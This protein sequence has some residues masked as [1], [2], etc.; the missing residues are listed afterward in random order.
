MAIAEFG[1]FSLNRRELRETI[2][3]KDALGLQWDVKEARETKHGFDILYGKRH[4]ATE[5]DVGGPNRL[6]YTHELKA[7]WEKHAIDHDG[8]I[9]DLPAGRTTLKRARIALGFNWDKDS[10]K[11]WRKRKEDM[12]TLKPREFEEK[13]REH[14]VTG[15]RMSFWRKRMVGGRARPLDWWKETG[16]LNIL[17]SG[18]S[19][20][21]MRKVLPEKISTTQAGRLRRRARQCYRLVDGEIQCIGPDP[22]C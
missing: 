12:K 22:A 4:N 16:V 21:E 11:F 19:L 14:K 20:N 7:F 17:L 15:E 1:F 2:A 3:I 5:Y 6:I 10:E 18:K 8:T 13:H 9:F